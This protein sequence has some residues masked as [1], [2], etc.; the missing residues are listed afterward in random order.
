MANFFDQ[1]DAPA[2]STPRD[3]PARPAG[4]FF[5]QFDSA[6]APRAASFNERFGGTSARREAT[7]APKELQPLAEALR[8]KADEMLVGKPS[9]AN[10]AAAAV[11]PGANALGFNVPRAIGAL[12]ASAPL[13]GNGRTYAQNYD[14][15]KD[16][17]EALSR[18]YPKTSIAG[19]VA[20][21]GA[22]A[23]TL[24]GFQ[25]AQGAGAASRIGAAALTGAGY[26]AAGSILD[27][28]DA[29]DVGKGAVIGGVIGGV[30]APIAERVAG[31]LAPFFE[32]GVATRNSAGQFTDEAR[33]YLSRAGINPLEIDQRSERAI[34][35]AF[36]A[37]G[38]NE[39]ALNEG[40]AAAQ[41]ISLTRGQATGDYAQQQ[42]EALAARNG[43]NAGQK[44]LADALNAQQEQISAR[45]RAIGEDLAGG[46]SV[47]GS[48]YEAGELVAS[49]ARA[50]ANSADYRS[51]EGEGLA[52]AALSNLRGR[53]DPLEAG[54][55]VAGRG[56]SLVGDAAAREAAAV[57]EAQQSLERLRGPDGIDAL[58]AGRTVA[59]N[60]RSAAARDK[61]RYQGAYAEAGAIPGEFVPGALDRVG[62]R[63]RTELPPEVLVDERLTPGAI[64]AL[65]DMDNLPG[66]FRLDEGAGP[67]LRQVEQFRKRLG[68]YFRGASP[69]DA[70]ALGEIRRQFDDRVQLAL[71]N[72][73]FGPRVVDDFPGSLS[74]RVA[75]PMAPAA[76]AAVPDRKTESLI[77]YLGRRGGIALDDDARAADLGRIQTGF[78]PLGRRGGRAIDDFRD[79]LAAEGF[80]RPD[81]PDGMISR[82]ISDEIY[83]LIGIERAGNSVTRLEDASA[84]RAARDV[85]GRL[86]DQSAAAE[87]RA[88]VFSDQIRAEL[89]AAG[90]SDRE[91][92]VG[93]LRDAAL[94]MMRG[95]TDDAAE[96]YERAALGRDPRGSVSDDV[97]FPAQ[98]DATVRAPEM[99]VPDGYPDPSEAWRNA[100]A[101]F[102]EYSRT[103][104][105][106]GSGD[107]VGRVMRAIVDRAAEPAEVARFL[108]QGNP[109]TNLRVADRLRSVLGADSPEWAAIGQGYIARIASGADQSPEAISRRIAA[110]LE[111]DNRQLAQ[112]LLSDDQVRGLRSYQAAVARAG[113]ARGSIP[114]WA[115]DLAANNFDPQKVAERLY[116]A[117]V[118]GRSSSSQYADGLRGFFGAD[119]P[120]WRAIQQGYISHVLGGV[121]MGGDA[122]G[123]RVAATLAPENRLFAQRMLTPEQVKGLE[124]VQRGLATAKLTR[125]SVPEW[126]A[127]LAKSDFDPRRVA[128]KML[129]T[130][131]PGSSAAAAQYTQALK[132]F[133]GK[134]SQEWAAIRQA[135]WQQLVNKP[136]GF[137]GDYGAQAQ[138]N[139]IAEFLERKGK[140]LASVLY[141]PQ[142][143]A[144]MREYAAVLRLLV[145]QR[146]AGGSAS[147]N[148]DTAPA[149]AAM[150]RRVSAKGN[151][152]AN[153]LGVANLATGGVL[154][155]ALG[156]AFGKGVA[157]VADRVQN[158]A[159]QRFAQE[160][161]GGAP[162]PLPPPRPANSN[163]NLPAAVGATEATNELR[164]R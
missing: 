49:R 77:Q 26:G 41:G 151:Q 25:A 82:K 146:L 116:G 7:E 141:S 5:D 102:A 79:E 91:I 35:E 158:R 17:E 59:E 164:Q 80:I 123:K 100:R 119:S 76:Q 111:G 13:I 10:Q 9:A 37:K 50:V 67:N 128:E 85:G 51:S 6:P 150:L 64:S 153:T 97:P 65:R 63:I 69:E 24:P 55:L 33:A 135:A 60:V 143:L 29:A 8:A 78:G 2:A 74:A 23:L 68:S 20:G 4:N 147:P 118:G 58:D 86:A 16:Q 12:A 90:L 88:G 73:L 113:E 22:G 110:A 137:V 148:S 39:A 136:E 45:Q 34:M 14:L 101:Q 71:D 54:A 96:A 133:L 124:A 138:A 75:E 19:T 161:V 156:W 93:T 129:G 89:R 56:R 1:F 84:G 152:I 30:A 47:V 83:D 28:K 52:N 125:E 120:E 105:P 127:D 155:G 106:Q 163:Y 160:A 98:G 109:G 43:E 18:Q 95:E 40:R 15:A 142:E 149:A 46:R 62:T 31:A 53:V 61:A 162:V 92:D 117:S 27:A 108:Y 70:R 131:A 103:Y 107:D 94:R 48:P 115:S 38:I 36:Q 122:L 154:R 145:P 114:A 99:G 144:Q 104:R 32:K 140:T 66:L 126:I 112:R 21:I 157:K 130:T 3:E 81:T 11:I 42:A 159:E 57:R 72:G 87:G 121:D 134:D 44:V 139:R 132:G